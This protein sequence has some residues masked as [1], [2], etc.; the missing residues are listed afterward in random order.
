MGEGNPEK[1]CCYKIVL[2]VIPIS[3]MS[4]SI[5]HYELIMKVNVLVIVKL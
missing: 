1:K 5:T 4:M 3:H 2:S